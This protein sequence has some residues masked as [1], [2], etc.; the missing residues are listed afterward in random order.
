[1]HLTQVGHLRKPGDNW[2]LGDFRRADGADGASAVA[3]GR[4]SLGFAAVRDSSRGY[5]TSAYAH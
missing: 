3:S 1:M 5:L 4:R 2:D